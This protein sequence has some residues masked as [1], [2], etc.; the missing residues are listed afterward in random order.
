M[1]EHRPEQTLDLIGRQVF[2]RDCR[3]RGAAGMKKVDADTA[4][5]A[6]PLPFLVKKDGVHDSQQPPPRGHFRINPVV[7]VKGANQSFLHQFPDVFG[8]PFEKAGAIVQRFDEVQG[9]TAESLA[10]VP[11]GLRAGRLQHWWRAEPVMNDLLEH[12]GAM[13]P[14]SESRR[15]VQSNGTLAGGLARD[16]CNSSPEVNRGT[17]CTISPQS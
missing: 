14:D 16:N 5:A 2:P 3:D 17:Y 7:P 15:A 9:W 4:R 11:I 8:C 10:L 13:R 1:D 12:E 6:F